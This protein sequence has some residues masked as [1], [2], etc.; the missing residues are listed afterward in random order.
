MLWLRQ[1]FPI[2]IIRSRWFLPPW[3]KRDAITLFPFIFI[4]PLFYNSRTLR[5]H[6]LIHIYQ[7]RQEGWFAFY[8][9]YL[10][11]KLFRRT[12]YRDLDYEAEAYYHQTNP[13]HLP[14]ALEDR[15]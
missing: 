8:V 12:H 9:R 3:G 4:R 6:E 2:F 10:W 14:P 1:R 13:K 15:V 11:L 5:R 7:I